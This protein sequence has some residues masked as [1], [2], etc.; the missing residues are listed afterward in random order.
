MYL[1]AVIRSLTVLATFKPSLAQI[2]LDLQW[3]DDVSEYT[4]QVPVGTPGQNITMRIEFETFLTNYTLIPSTNSTSCMNTTDVY[5]GCPFGSFNPNLSTTFSQGNTYPNND[6]LVGTE[7]FDTIGLGGISGNGDYVM[8]LSNGSEFADNTPAVKNIEPSLPFLYLLGDIYNYWTSIFFLI[9]EP[10]SLAYAFSLWLEDENSWTGGLLLGAIDTDRYEGDLVSLDTYDRDTLEAQSSKSSHLS[11]ER[12]I[13]AIAMTSL[14]ASSPTGTDEIWV[15]GPLFVRMKLGD[16]IWLSPYLAAQIRNITGATVR[17]DETGD[18]EYTVIPCNMKNSEGY[19]TF[20]FGGPEAFRVNVTMAS[21]VVQPPKKLRQLFNSF[22]ENMCRFGISETQGYDVG[23]LS[24]H[25][26]RSVYTVVD[27][28][29]NKVAMAPLRLGNRD[30]KSSIVTFDGIGAPIPSATS[31]S[32]QP[33]SISRIAL[34]ETSPSS[35]YRAA[36]GFGS[37]TI[38]TTPSSSPPKEPPKPSSN[39]GGNGFGVTAKIAIIVSISIATIFILILTFVVWRRLKVRRNLATGVP[40][41]KQTHSIQ[42]E[43]AGRLWM[44]QI[45]EIDGI[46]RPAELPGVKEPSEL[47]DTG[48]CAELPGDHEFPERTAT[49]AKIEKEPSIQIAIKLAGD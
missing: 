5:E 45:Y 23:F 8:L 24:S 1:L 6:P 34:V 20:G 49:E 31:A 2:L 15:Q 46:T 17:H 22:G 35:S 27:L 16:D 41:Q 37:L 14:S 7:F 3:S 47:H 19:F 43:S 9:P 38:A 30:N 36:D 40:F 21:L 48:V 29:N 26:L 42:R 11:D 44:R 32:G 12:P 25:L 4:A 18:Y 13:L 33:S 39:L 10:Y 28:A